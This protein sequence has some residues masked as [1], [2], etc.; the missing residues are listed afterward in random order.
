MGLAREGVGR[1]S[2]LAEWEA[3]REDGLGARG[4][5]MCW[6]VGCVRRHASWLV[7]WVLVG[8]SAVWSLRGRQ[9]SRSSLLHAPRRL[10]SSWPRA[11]GGF[12]MQKVKAELAEEKEEQAEVQA[13]MAQVQAKEEEVEELFE[14]VDLAVAEAAVGQAAAVK[15]E[16]RGAKR[17]TTSASS[18]SPTLRRRMCSPT[19]PP[20]AASGAS[21]SGASAS[22]DP[23]RPSAAK[24]SS[25]AVPQRA[26]PPAL[27]AKR[28]L[29]RRQREVE[30]RQ[31]LDRAIASRARGSIAA[32]LPSS[33]DRDWWAEIRL[34]ARALQAA[35]AARVVFNN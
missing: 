7:G 6:P 23:S 32:S 33:A 29:V 24:S 12:T 25:P 27:L 1:V 2:F 10:A 26:I 18:D 19:R 31:Q 34:R 28:E 8:R 13:E 15:Q 14:E 30:R 9:L 35:Q 20:G 17:E 5:G 16:V 21:A 22:G 11:P 4:S 3:P